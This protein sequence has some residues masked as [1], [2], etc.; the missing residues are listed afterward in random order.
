MLA[1][2]R[3]YGLPLS[4]TPQPRLEEGFIR[5]GL[6]VRWGLSFYRALITKHQHRSSTT[7]FHSSAISPAGG[8]SMY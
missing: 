1:R 7:G 2:H 4:L 3:T 8:I 6:S 5:E